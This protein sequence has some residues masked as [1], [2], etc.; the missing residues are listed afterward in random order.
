MKPLIRTGTAI[1]WLVV[2]AVA[3][4][5][6][7]ADIPAGVYVTPGLGYIVRLAPCATGAVCA[8]LLG[9]LLPARSGPLPPPVAGSGWR[10]L[11][12]LAATGDRIGWLRHDGRSAVD[13]LMCADPGCGSPHWRRVGRID[14]DLGRIAALSPF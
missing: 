5:P 1:L 10:R 6:A 3:G 14:P 4:G 9:G 12:I 2:A 13:I 11:P 7:R 8:T